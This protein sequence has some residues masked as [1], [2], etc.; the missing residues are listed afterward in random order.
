MEKQSIL[1]SVGEIE[2]YARLKKFEPQL[3]V[4]VGMRFFRVIDY[5]LKGL[6]K[7]E[8][9]FLRTTEFDFVICTGPKEKAQF[10]IEYDGIGK[11]YAEVDPHRPLKQAA[12]EKACRIS[13]FPLLTLGPLTDIEGISVL[14]AI[15]ESYLGG[16][17]F[18]AMISSGYLSLEES[19]IYQ[20]PPLTKL[21]TKF[22]F[23]I[24]L[25]LVDIT[26]PN[27]AQR[28][29]T[30]QTDTTEVTIKKSASVRSVSFPHFH[31][32]ELADDIAQF[33]CLQEFG[34]RLAKG[35]FSV[36]GLRKKIL[37]RQ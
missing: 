10:A 22:G 33:R 3:R 5:H 36:E 25:N 14:E 4:H 30:F 18:S 32:L 15:I 31:A 17:A 2:L 11:N 7:R 23:S 21:I 37:H 16:D 12:K 34:D 9:E 24:R 19:F 35:E 8:H 29:I 26:A 27:A 13:K 20:F 1:D 28:T 6:T